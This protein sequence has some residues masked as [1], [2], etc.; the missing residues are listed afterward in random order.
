VDDEALSLFAD[1]LDDH[2]LLALS[3]ELRIE[4]SLPRSQVELALRDGK[5]HRL[6]E[7]QAFEMRVSV[8]LARLVVAVVLPERRELFQPF[9]D[10]VNQAGLIVVH[11]HGRRDM[12]R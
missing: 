10:V 4:D 7:Q 5:R 8:V 6:V 12:H 1:D 9:V 3:V 2:P 11:V